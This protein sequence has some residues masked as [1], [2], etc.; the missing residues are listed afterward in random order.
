MIKYDVA[1][2]MISSVDTDIM[3]S[4]IQSIRDFSGTIECSTIDSLVFYDWD[5]KINRL[6][7]ECSFIMISSVDTDIMTSIIQSIREFSRAIECSILLIFEYHMTE[8]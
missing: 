3:I 2:I 7:W 6:L 1:N 4:I 5:V 8:M